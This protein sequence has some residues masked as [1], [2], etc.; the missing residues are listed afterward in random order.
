MAALGKLGEDLKRLGVALMMEMSPL[1]HQFTAEEW[2]ETNVGGKV[3]EIQQL[4]K[5]IDQKLTNQT[6]VVGKLENIQLKTD[7][8]DEMDRI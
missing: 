1:L 4:L 5:S 8:R 6:N 2:V 3:G 7:K